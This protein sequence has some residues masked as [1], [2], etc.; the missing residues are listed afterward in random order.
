MNIGV[1]TKR[2]NT[3]PH[4]AVAIGP[5]FENSRLNKE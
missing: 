1:I 4:E 3:I 2:S 5:R